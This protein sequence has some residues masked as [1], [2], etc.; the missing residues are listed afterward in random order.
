VLLA[1]LVDWLVDMPKHA[2]KCIE[3]KTLEQRSNGFP[4]CKRAKSTPSI[5]HG[6][7]VS[8]RSTPCLSVALT[9]Y[10]NDDGNNYYF[11]TSSSSSSSSSSS[12]VIGSCNSCRTI[13][14]HVQA[15]HIAQ[16]ESA[17]WALVLGHG[18]VPF[19]IVL[20]AN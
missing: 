4:S 12:Y 10:Y 9:R 13:V 19:S 14:G 6:S 18:V 8:L 5:V 3:N 2:Y 16:L 15:N 17:V 7:G 20:S 11:Y 1:S